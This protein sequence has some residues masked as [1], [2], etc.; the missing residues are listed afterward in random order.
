MEKTDDGQFDIIK[1]E[2]KKIVIIPE[3]T[4]LYRGSAFSKNMSNE[5]LA[6]KS[7][8]PQ[9]FGFKTEDVEEYGIIHEYEVTKELRLYKVDD[10]ETL[11]KIYSGSSEKIQEIITNNYGYPGEKQF[12]LNDRE[13]IK[14][15]DREF[16]NSLCNEVDGYYSEKRKL[17]NWTSENEELIREMTICNAYKKVKLVANELSKNFKDNRD[18]GDEKYKEYIT[19][20][21]LFFEQKTL[22]EKFARDRKEKNEKKREEQRRKRNRR[23]DERLDVFSENISSTPPKLIKITPVSEASG[24][25]DDSSEMQITP[26]TS[27][28]KGNLFGKYFTPGG[29]K[30]SKKSKKSKKIKKAKKQTRKKKGKKN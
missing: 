10:Y 18:I 12:T 26:D 3:G 29:K 7:I 9:F 6:E 5:N 16:A 22:D 14:D 13:T 2:S 28:Q 25:I 11:E 30:K 19:D 24:N 4:I 21:R 27:P 8:R 1:E 15:S 20:R 17:K 23:E